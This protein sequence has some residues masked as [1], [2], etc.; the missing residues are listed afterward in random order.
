MMPLRRIRFE[1]PCRIEVEHSDSALCAHVVLA[2]GVALNPGDRLRVHGDPIHVG[3]GEARVFERI[4]TVER[5]NIFER[6]WTKLAAHLDLTELYEVSFSPRR[7][8]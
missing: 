7:M 2:G 6:L 4:A 3:F 5:A 8:S 1:A